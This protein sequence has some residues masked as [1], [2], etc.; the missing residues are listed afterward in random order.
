MNESTQRPELLFAKTL[1]RASPGY[2]TAWSVL[3]VL[4]GVLPAVVSLA[5]GWLVSAV[6]RGASLT[7]PLVLV[8]SVFTA[9]LVVQPL[10]QMV[11]SNLGSRTAAHLY[12][13]LMTLCVSPAGVGHLESS[14]LVNDLAMARDFDLGMMGPPL[15]VSM[16]FICAKAVSG[17][18]AT[19]TKCAT[20]NATPTTPTGSPSTPGPRRRFATSGSQVGSSTA[21][22]RPAVGCTTCSTKQP[23]CARSRCSPVS[24][25]CSLRT[26]SCSG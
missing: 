16:D 1:F 13:R 8:G 2:A 3:V 15:S 5:F 12:D 20:R 21:S 11:S 24:S 9:L 18:T 26:C 22:S 14:A 19:P 25:S 23:G 17:K 4:R 10:H 6:S 7:G